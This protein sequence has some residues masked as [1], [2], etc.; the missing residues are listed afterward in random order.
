MTDSVNFPA[1]YQS[2]NGVECIEAI[3]AAMTTEEFFGYLRGNCIKYIWRYRQKNS[4]DPSED[5]R[6]ARWYLCRL[7]LEFETSPYDDSLA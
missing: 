1:H 5:L 2:T 6:K 7:I 4:S 3:K